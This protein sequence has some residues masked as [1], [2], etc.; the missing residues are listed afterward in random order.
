MSDTI[1]AF[2]IILCLVLCLYFKKTGTIFIVSGIFA[3]SCLVRIN[4]IFFAPLMAYLFWRILEDTKKTSFY[5]VFKQGLI[6]IFIFLLIFTPQLIFNKLMHGGFFTFPYI[7]HPNRAA[8]GFAMNHVIQGINYLVSCNYIFFAPCSVFL[9]F[10]KR[11]VAKNILV[12]WSIPLVIFFTGY[13][14]LETNPVRFILPVYGALIAI[15]LLADQGI[16]K[17]RE[18][19]IFFGILAINLLCCSPIHRFELVMPF[20][21]QISTSWEFINSIF[22]YATPALSLI[23]CIFLL[24]ANKKLLLFLIIYHIGSPYLV[25]GL[26]I[27]SIIMV[28]YD[29][30]KEIKLLNTGDLYYGKNEA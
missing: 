24:K 10:M 2:L 23:L 26:L 12:L 20:D 22:V 11:S 16:E 19:L 25:F 13:P 29:I 1:S 8:E 14:C 27:C 9:L 28:L 21:M 17:L 4:N 5:D 3:F 15:C 30:S 6:S 7:M 18:K